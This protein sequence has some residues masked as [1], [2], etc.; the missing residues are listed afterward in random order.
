MDRRVIDTGSRE[1]GSIGGIVAGIR[2]IGSDIDSIRR[3]RYRAWEGGLLP[4]RGSLVCKSRRRKRLT[5]AAPQVAHMSA[6]VRSALV[7][8]YPSDEAVEVNPELDPEF[9]G[10][11]IVNRGVCRYG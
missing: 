6:S 10:V 8:A 4:A 1:V 2:V 7:K 5:G 3:H 9:Y 11:G